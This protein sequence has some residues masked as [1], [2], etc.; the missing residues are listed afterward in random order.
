MLH[1]VNH[2]LERSALMSVLFNSLMD[3]G[4]SSACV[5]YKNGQFVQTPINTTQECNSPE[6]VKDVGWRLET[7]TEVRTPCEKFLATPLGCSTC[8]FMGCCRPS[9][10]AQFRISLKNFLKYIDLQKR[11]YTV[12]TVSCPK[13]LKIFNIVRVANVYVDL[14]PVMPGLYSAQTKSLLK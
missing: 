8:D 2:F 9:T 4:C 11:G 13:Y 14:Y 5:A 10:W 3:C 12:L 7:I 6:T 1:V